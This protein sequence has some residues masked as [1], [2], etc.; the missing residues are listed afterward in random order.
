MKEQITTQLNA[1]MTKYNRTV[2][3]DYSFFLTKEQKEI[4]VDFIAS[5]IEKLEKE[6]D[7]AEQQIQ[8]LDLELQQAYADKQKL[9][10]SIKQL[11]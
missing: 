4:I 7:V 9:I 1:I 3:N 11:L 5:K 10:K 8:K 2:R 6:N